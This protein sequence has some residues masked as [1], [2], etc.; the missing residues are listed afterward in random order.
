MEQRLEQLA[1]KIDYID[2]DNLY[3]AINDIKGVL[4]ELIDIAKEFNTKQ[5]GD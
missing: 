5:G 3:Q 1:N 2:T 4:V